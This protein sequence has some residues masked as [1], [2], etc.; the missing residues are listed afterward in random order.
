MV[1]QKQRFQHLVD[2]L[3]IC[4]C[5]I[6]KALIQP[7][8]EG[9]KV[10]METHTAKKLLKNT[11]IPL[12]RTCAP[13]HVLVNQFTRA[14]KETYISTRTRNPGPVKRNFR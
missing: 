10:E 3:S 13:I 12:Q 7:P 4:E 9:H 6:S 11:Q 2:T 5:K 1:D 14:A 8:E